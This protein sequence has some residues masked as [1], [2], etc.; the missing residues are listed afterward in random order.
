MQPLN[1]VH[2]YTFPKKGIQD[3]FQISGKPWIPHEVP[4]QKFMIGPHYPRVVFFSFPPEQAF[5]P[6]EILVNVLK[7]LFPAAISVFT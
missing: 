5:K 7:S 3:L 1:E 4:N 6:P 2:Y